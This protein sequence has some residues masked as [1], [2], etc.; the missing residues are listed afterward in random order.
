MTLPRHA[1]ALLIG[2]AL[3]IATLG[4]SGAGHAFQACPEC[5]DVQLSKPC[6]GC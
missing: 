5:L 3:L 4:I 1:R 2:V 6:P